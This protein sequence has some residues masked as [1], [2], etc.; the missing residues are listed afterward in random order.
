MTAPKKKIPAAK[1]T[2]TTASN[3]WSFLNT[4]AARG[5]V[6]YSTS[7]PGLPTLVPKQPVKPKDWSFVTAGT[8]VGN[9]G[10]QS[11]GPFYYN[12]PMVKSAYFN[13]LSL[14]KAP[15]D[16][17]K[18]VRV[19]NEFVNV[20]VHNEGREGLFHFV[21]Q[22]VYNDAKKAWAVNADGS[23]AGGKGTI[24]M[25]RQTNTTQIL[26]QAVQAAKK[27]KKTFDGNMYGFKFLYNPKEVNMSWGAVANANPQFEAMNL[28]TIA[29]ISANM[30]SSTITFDIILNRMEDMVVLNPNGTYTGSNPYPSWSPAKGSNQTAELKKIVE[31][32]TM[33]D[34]EYLFKSLHGYAGNSNFVSSLRGQTSDP[35]W[36]PVRPVE[37]HLGN[38]LRYRVRV[39]NLAVRHAIFN[40]RMVPVFSTVSLTCNRYWD[41]QVSSA[42]VIK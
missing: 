37:L 4:L 8:G 39:S 32:G 11:K 27:Q 35:G 33:Y 3:G 20:S 14:P 1:T 42:G 12:A 10:T 38:M 28:D 18:R 25:D 41:G 9:V 15:S 21:D 40:S 17:L 24:Q 19:G 29:P 31:M 36:L 5:P 6:V 26:A 23:I 34:L 30:L 7:I 16:S 13:P 2:A 22:G